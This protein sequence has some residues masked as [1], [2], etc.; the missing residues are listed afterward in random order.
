MREPLYLVNEESCSG[1]E[2]STSIESREELDWIYEEIRKLP[3]VDRSLALL[4][5][6]PI[7]KLMFVEMPLFATL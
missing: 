2:P 3:G 7:R 4:Y 6:E 5:L 1:E